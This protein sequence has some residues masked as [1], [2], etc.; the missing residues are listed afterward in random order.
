MKK[1]YFFLLDG[2]VAVLILT[3]GFLLIS[4]AHPDKPSTI[5]NKRAANDVANVLANTKIRD[6]CVDSPSCSCTDAV[7]RDLYCTT[8]GI[9]NKDN[10]LLELVGELYDRNGENF[11]PGSLRGDEWANAVLA[12]MAQ[13]DDIYGEAFII[14]DVP[15][16][17]SINTN[18]YPDK[19]SFY[20][21]YDLGMEQSRIL[22][23]ARKVVMGYYFE[24][25]GIRM[26]GPYTVE[27]LVWQR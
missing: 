18:I 1:G 5:F 15:V 17:N 16:Y 27:V 19:D 20:S 11:G 26:W 24:D 25:P 21:S 22:V 9:M 3:V 12:S 13:M 23:S 8:G 14:D 7:V 10:T 4:S 6:I 2:L